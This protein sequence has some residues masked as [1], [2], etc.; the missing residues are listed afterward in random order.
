MDEA[1]FA[2]WATKIGIGGLMA[3][4]AFI[5]YDLGKK[6]NAGK[7]GMM[8]LFFVL[9]FGTV[10]LIVKSIVTFFLDK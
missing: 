4:M 6:H 7:Y 3:F 10:G 5:V 8:V 1:V 2:D 9:G